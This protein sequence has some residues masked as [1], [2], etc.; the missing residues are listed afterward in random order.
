MEGSVLIKDDT[1]QIAVL[2]TEMKHLEQTISDMRNDLKEIKE[3]LSEARG[4]WK[5][6][7]LVAGISSSVG[8]LA[9]KF[10]PWL[11]AAPR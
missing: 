3:T 1:V 9:V 10:T 4:G 7:M 11:A 2:K 8:A 6:L 5:T